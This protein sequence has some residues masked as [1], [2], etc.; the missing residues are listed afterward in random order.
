MY[1][2]HGANDKRGKSTRPLRT[3]LTADRTNFIGTKRNSFPLVHAANLTQPDFPRPFLVARYLSALSRRT[4][5]RFTLSFSQ[6]F[7]SLSV[8]TLGHVS[9]RNAP[10][11][12][13]N[14]SISGRSAARLGNRGRG[15]PKG[16]LRISRNFPSRKGFTS[17]PCSTN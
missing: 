11:L 5:P 14:E 7:I 12:S 4:L 15:R 8:P 17:S 2:W 9:A 3:A 16:G 13:A 6:T 10:N 1:T